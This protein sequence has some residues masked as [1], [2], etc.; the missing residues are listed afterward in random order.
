MIKQ[1][2]T[3]DHAWLFIKIMNWLVLCSNFV[4]SWWHMCWHE[5]S[6]L[7]MHSSD[8]FCFEKIYY[9]KNHWLFLKIWIFGVFTVNLAYSLYF[10]C[11]CCQKLISLCHGKCIN[12]VEVLEKAQK[13]HYFLQV[14]VPGRPFGR[15]T[16]I[17]ELIVFIKHYDTA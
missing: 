16:I 5:V 17:S 2:P 14:V 7:S 9:E 13:V 12:C 8:E 3:F 1:Y 6:H 10:C 4:L 15:K 11:F